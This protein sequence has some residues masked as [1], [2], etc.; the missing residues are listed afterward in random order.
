M[1]SHAAPPVMANTPWLTG[2]P[3]Q[4]PLMYKGL[5]WTNKDSEKN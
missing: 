5:K 4:T 2:L 1:V 3:F